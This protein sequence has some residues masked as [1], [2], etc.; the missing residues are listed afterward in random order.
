MREKSQKTRRA[1]DCEDK[2]T[3]RSDRS[4]PAGEGVGRTFKRLLLVS[5]A[6][7]EKAVKG[8]SCSGDSRYVYE[9]VT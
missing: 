4:P 2:P 1:D 6:S 9:V 5:E 8:N 7:V 3:R